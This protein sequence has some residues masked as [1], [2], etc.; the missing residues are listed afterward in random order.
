MATLTHRA[1]IPHNC[2]AHPM[3]PI[4][5]L[6]RLGE[7]IHR[8]TQ[9]WVPTWSHRIKRRFC[10]GPHMY[11]DEIPPGVPD[12]PARFRSWDVPDAPSLTELVEQGDAMIPPPPMSHKNPMDHDEDGPDGRC[13]RCLK[14][15]TFHSLMQDKGMSATEAQI[16]VDRITKDNLNGLPPAWLGGSAQDLTRF[17]RE[18]EGYGG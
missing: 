6:W 5:V 4:P 8:N 14:A 2:I 15:K 9:E 12:E 16:T 11:L 1:G 13:L 10:K 17:A 7:R 18:H 3:L